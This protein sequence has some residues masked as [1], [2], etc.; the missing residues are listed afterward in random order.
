MRRLQLLLHLF[1]YPSNCSSSC[2]H[3]V[4][5]DHPELYGRI[6]S[7]VQSKRFIPVGG[8]YV[9]FDANI[10]SGE[11]MV[12]Q[13]L[14]GL[15]IFRDVTAG[16]TTD[17]A[18]AVQPRESPSQSAAEEATTKEATRTTA[19]R[20]GVFWLPDTFGYSAQLPQIMRGFGIPYFLSSKLCWNLF[21]KWVH[22][23]R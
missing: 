11:S 7:S 2:F 14:Y 6:Q 22:Y 12:R 9:E 15:D 13:F 5:E 17:G 10:P 19:W 21:N 20:P 16:R 4:K 18:S 23:E 1:V 3:R 8:S